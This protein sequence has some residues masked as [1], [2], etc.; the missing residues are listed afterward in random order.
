MSPCCQRWNLLPLALPR[1][2]EVY[3]PL[4]E[5]GCCSVWSVGSSTSCSFVIW[6]VY[7]PPRTLLCWLCLDSAG[8][9][10]LEFFID[11]YY[12]NQ[13]TWTT[14]CC[15][16][17]PV[18]GAS[19]GTRPESKCSGI[20]HVVPLCKVSMRTANSLFW[21]TTGV[22]FCGMWGFVSGGLGV[23]EAL[24]IVSWG[25]SCP[26]SEGRGT[27]KASPLRDFGIKN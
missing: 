14:A 7:I 4:V 9:L 3:K 12:C 21:N 11:T 25:A 8:I 5:S 16:E 1:L 27:L 24:K 23:R 20:K 17:T 15:F 26:S 6:P 13:V 18:S 2:C 10:V 22:P 19:H